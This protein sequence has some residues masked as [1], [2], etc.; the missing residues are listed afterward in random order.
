MDTQKIIQ[1]V[2]LHVS[3]QMKIYSRVKA[4]WESSYACFEIF[5]KL[6][7]VR[8]IGSICLKSWELISEGHPKFWITHFISNEALLKCKGHLQVKLYLF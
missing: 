5:G 1:S 8:E 4:N 7:R 3:Y 6:E 2:K